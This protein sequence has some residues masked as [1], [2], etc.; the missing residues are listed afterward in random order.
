M[1]HI[2]FYTYPVVQLEQWTPVQKGAG[3][4]QAA[5]SKY[6]SHAVRTVSIILKYLWQMEKSGE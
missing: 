5:I 2:K 4:E 1:Y 6:K 3:S